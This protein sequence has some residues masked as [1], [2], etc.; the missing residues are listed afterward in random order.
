MSS[1]DDQYEQ[2]NDFT[3]GAPVG[4]VSDNNYMSRIGRSQILVRKGD[5]LVED[6]IDSATA[7][8]D[9]TLGMFISRC[10]RRLVDA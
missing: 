10:S 4:N 5:A 1:P 8:S 6:P 2:Q 9:E 3:S 7:D